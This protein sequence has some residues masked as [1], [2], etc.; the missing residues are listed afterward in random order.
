M[1]FAEPILLAGF[2]LVPLALLAYGALQRRGRRESSAWANPAL[3]PSLATARPG[4]R[5]HVPPLLLLLALCALVA[6]L[7][8]PQRTVAAPQRAA[9][10]IMVT[11]I[12]G[13]M[14]A[15]DVKPDRLSAAIAAAKTLTDKVPDTFRLG[16]VTFSDFA[17]QRVAP[18]TDRAQIK[19]ALGQLV[20][21]GGTAMGDGLERGLFAARTPVP[22]AD[23]SGVRRLPSVIVLLSDGKNTSG[24]RDPVDVAREAGSVH[25]PIYAIALGTPGGEVE[26]RDAFGFMQRVQ[27]PPDIETLKQIAQLS[28]G[29]SYTATETDKLKEI[30]ATLGTR[31][32]SRSEKHEVTAAFAGGALVLLVAAGSL[33]LR[34]FGKL[35]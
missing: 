28:G 12:S 23:G 35:I 19:G 7:A 32:S 4:W 6:A 34:W 5:R 2:I 13:S 17:E 30:Y 8:R 14:N 11:D 27:V 15:T 22:N 21:E 9:N 24:T 33:S 16:L 3:A 1:S 25:V 20:A 31:L 10:V 18:T 26:L 29:R